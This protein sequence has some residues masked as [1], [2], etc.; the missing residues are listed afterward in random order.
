MIQPQT[1][2]LKQ[3]KQL[4]NRNTYISV[5]ISKFLTVYHEHHKYQNKENK[6]IWDAIEILDDTVSQLHNEI[7]NIKDQL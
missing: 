3:L 4:E 5:A 7:N 2:Q 1:N 6:E